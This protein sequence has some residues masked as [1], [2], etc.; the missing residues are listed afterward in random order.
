MPKKEDILDIFGKPPKLLEVELVKVKKSYNRFPDLY[1]ERWQINVKFE[2]QKK[3]VW[4]TST[5]KKDIIK[6]YEKL[7]GKVK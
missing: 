6:E 1:S 3:K 5:Y 2:G 4:S 7:K